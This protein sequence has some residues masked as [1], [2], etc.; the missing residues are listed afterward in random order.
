MII[1]ILLKR[2]K[3]F[4][5]ISAYLS[6]L[7]LISFRKV[8]INRVSFESS[9]ITES[10]YLDSELTPKINYNDC[11]AEILYKLN[12]PEA[13]FQVKIDKNVNSFEDLENDLKS[14]SLKFGGRW[15]P[16][17][18]KSSQ[19]IAI[20]I[21]YRDRLINMKLFLKNM[22]PFLVRQNIQYGVYFVEPVEKLAFNRG[23]LMNAGF[24]E[25]LTDSNNLWNC[26]FFHDVDMIAMDERNIYKCDRDYPVH[27]A[28]SLSKFNYNQ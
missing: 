21:P 22:H 13:S 3:L 4:L 27:Y 11:K 5:F 18:C 14:L 26:F 12:D 10:N 16:K 23:T 15:S 25:S 28:V 20:I 17:N 6:L 8:G 24:I 9:N 19:K 2:G 1:R 7:F